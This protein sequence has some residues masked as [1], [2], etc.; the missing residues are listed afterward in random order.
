VYPVT[1]FARVQQIL[2]TVIASWSHQH[3]RQPVLAKHDA[4]F[5]WGT[6]DQLVNSKAFGLPLIAQD[7][8]DGKDGA[9]ANIVVALRTGVP[10]YPRMPIR[11]PYLDDTEIQEIIDWIDAGAL[12]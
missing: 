5:G 3:G 12:P 9:N 11:G 10:G 1:T 7:R 6:R 4:S 8:I 2:D